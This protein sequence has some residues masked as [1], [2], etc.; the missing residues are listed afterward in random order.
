MPEC[1]PK[2]VEFNIKNNAIYRLLLVKSCSSEG[3]FGLE[4]NASYKLTG[5]K[6]CL[7]LSLFGKRKE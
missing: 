2:S 7:A 1:I 3:M 6:K 4:P 5:V